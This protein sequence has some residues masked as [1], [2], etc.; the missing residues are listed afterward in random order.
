MNANTTAS[1]NTAVGWRALFT[2]TTGANNVAVGWS[3]LNVATTANN[4]IAIGYG[5]MQ[6]VTTGA[7][8]TAVG[9]FALDAS[10]TAT[11]NTALGYNSL[12]ANT[13]GYNNTSVGY[14][15]ADS[16]STGNN[17]TAL[18]ASSLGTVTTGSGNTAIGSNAH[19][20]GTTAHSNTVV[21]YNAGDAITTGYDNCI[22]GT[23]SG[24]YANAITTGAENTVIGNYART[25]SA[26]V[27]KEGVFGRYALGQGAETV[28]L[29]DNSDGVHIAINGSTTSWSAHSDERLKENITDA[30]AGL[31]FINDL[32]PITYNWKFKKDISPDFYNFYK[33]DSEEPV[34][35]NV[36]QTNHGFV[37]QEVKAVI[38]NHSEVKEGNSIWRESPDG[39]QNI[40]EGALM[41]MMVKAVQE[42][43]AKVEV[44]EKQLN[45]KE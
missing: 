27:S 34:Q 20:V 43:S 28:T 42:L 6:A 45:N 19:A 1:F 37:A 25:S 44:L 12:S 38:D 9:T 36:K 14:V 26:T 16:V 11:G 24:G 22:V 41:P 8:N 7:N 18:G 2:N 33:A 39:V 17:N 15:S 30:E 13:S 40:A 31:G 29:G 35:G 4:N 21:G 23:E 10:T 3:A 5:A 32:R